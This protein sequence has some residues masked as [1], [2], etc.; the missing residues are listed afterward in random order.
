MIV[1]IDKQLSAPEIQKTI[2]KIKSL[3]YTITQVT[4][5]QA[6]YLVCHGK[7]EIDI[8][9]IGALSGVKDVHVVSDSYKLVSR[10]WKVATSQVDIG[11]N[12]V[13]GNGNCSIVA[14]P[15]AIENEE[16]VAS[17]VNHLV[18]NNIKIMRGGVFKP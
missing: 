2:D 16:Q 14:G 9:F 8:R 11:N 10:K 1:Q 4:T 7:N 15:C 5:Q 3:G 17:I 12:I 13:I 18:E 6:Y